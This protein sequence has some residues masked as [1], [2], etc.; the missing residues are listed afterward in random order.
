MAY[1][2]F[3]ILSGS[4][5]TGP[6]SEDE[7]QTA[8][9]KDDIKSPL[10]WWRGLPE[11]LP[12]GQWER[13]LAELKKSSQQKAERLWKV[14]IEK[15]EATSMGQKQM[16]Q[17][18]SQQADLN[19]IEIWTEGYEDWHEVYQVHPI[20]DELGVSR[21]KHP[22]VPVAGTV[23]FVNGKKKLEAEPRTISEGGLGIANA[24]GLQ[25]GDKVSIMLRS[26]QLYLTIHTNA[27]VVY[28]NDKGIAGLKFDH[29]GSESRAAIIEYVKKFGQQNEGAQ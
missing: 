23:S 7:L 25:I 3:F 22:R 10:V 14:R 8:L 19:D 24:Q 12:P 29:L 1:P 21:R 17:F 28:A 26:P 5:V 11:W 16:I 27:E 20:M 15:G 18:L 4:E 2:N 6:Y 9:R 13:K